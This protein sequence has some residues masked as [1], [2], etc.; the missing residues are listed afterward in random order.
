MA[1]AKTIDQR[2]QIYSLVYKIKINEIYLQLYPYSF[3]IKTTTRALGLCKF[4][5]ETVNVF[6]YICL[7]SYSQSI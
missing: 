5:E 7:S 1:P 6:Y 3:I 4:N 2:R